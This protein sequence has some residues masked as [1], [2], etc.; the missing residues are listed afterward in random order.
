MHYT[1]I[2]KPRELLPPLLACL[3]ISFVSKRPPPALL[4]LLAP[5]L[6]Q[7]VSYINSDLPESPSWL[8]LLNWN[9][10]RAAKLP[11]VV[12]NVQIEPHPVS[13]EVEFEDV[14][15]IKY[16]RLDSETLETRLEIA[17]FGLIAIYLFCLGDGQEGGEEAGWR[18]SELRSLEDLD[19]STEWFDSIDEADAAVATSWAAITQH[20]DATAG[21]NGNGSSSEEKEEADDDDDY[22]GRYNATPGGATPEAKRSPAPQSRPGGVQMGPTTS[23]LEYF[24]R[25]AHEVQ[26]AMD[27]HDPD[28][29]GQLAPGDSTLNGQN[30][31]IEVPRSDGN[32]DELVTPTQPT[33]LGGGGGGDYGTFEPVIDTNGHSQPTE[34][35]PLHSPRPSSRRSTTSIQRLEN[36]ANN[37]T[38]AEIGVKQHIS[39]DI[40]SLFR[41]ARSVGID[42]SEFERIV[43]TELQCLSLMDPD[44]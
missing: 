5:L 42:Q 32:D 4:P 1:P 39:T 26:P 22:W 34:E 12:E 35:D 17:E 8:L 21:S 15:D 20:V 38:Q 19:D 10:E 18:L 37:Y 16:R 23:E 6:R 14:K 29:E 31:T 44:E 9:A 40:K 25:Y 36:Q 2:P 11:E 24:A 27:G 33:G 3:P 30:L 43:S 13:G 7:R 41:L 28:E